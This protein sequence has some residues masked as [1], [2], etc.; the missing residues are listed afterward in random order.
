MEIESA[1]QCVLDDTQDH[2]AFDLFLTWP[3]ND[4][5]L[6]SIRRQCLEIARTSSPARLGEDMSEN[7]KDRIRAVL[8]GLRERDRHA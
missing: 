6:E 2:D 4:P 3:I 5:Y 1:L 7:G 8:R